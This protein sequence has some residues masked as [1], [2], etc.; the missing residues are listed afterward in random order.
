[1]NFS[2]AAGPG[3]VLSRGE[4]VR[5]ESGRRRRLAQRCR[6]QSQEEEIS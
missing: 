4:L 2:P 1:M 6:F 5:K 3:N